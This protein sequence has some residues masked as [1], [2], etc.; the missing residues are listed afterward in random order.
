MN[1]HL[2][3]HLYSHFYLYQ[4]S[5]MSILAYINSIFIFHLYITLKIIKYI[6]LFKIMLKHFM[7][8]Q[9]IFS[10]TKTLPYKLYSMYLLYDTNLTNKRNVVVCY[11]TVYIYRLYRVEYIHSFYL[12]TW[13]TQ[14]TIFFGRQK[15]LKLGSQF[16][17]VN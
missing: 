15:A 3:L 17:H 9:F 14:K 2:N 4:K 8:T 10:Y 6:I 13:W 12:F 11:Y 16:N 5:D 7:Y 1:L